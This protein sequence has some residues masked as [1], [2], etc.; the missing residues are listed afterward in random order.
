MTL[1]GAQNASQTFS[2]L[3]VSRSPSPLL[4]SGFGPSG[5]PTFARATA[6]PTWEVWWR[7]WSSV[8]DRVQRHTQSSI[9]EHAHINIYTA[10]ESPR[11]KN[12]TW[13]NDEISWISW[14][15]F[16][17]Q[18]YIDVAS[19]SDKLFQTPSTGISHWWVAQRVSI[20]EFH[21]TC[22]SV[23]KKNHNRLHDRYTFIQSQWIVF[24]R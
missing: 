21:E 14:A 18:K 15:I 8:F 16:Y 24:I 13:R 2:I 23:S 10:F 22:H 12:R 1:Q 20:Y 6:P 11:T 3:S 4:L 7:P 19:V 5:F 17:T 9:G